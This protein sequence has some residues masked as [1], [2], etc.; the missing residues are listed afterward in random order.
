MTF[1]SASFFIFF[2]V[3]TT[4]YF[5]LP[6]RFR[7]A[8]LL[9]A[10]CIFYMAFVPAYILV[11]F[12]LILIDYT[13]AILIERS[14]G[15]RRTHFL[16]VSI[17]AMV[18]MLFVFKYFN[19]FNSNLYAL[20]HLLDW[21]YSF[22]FL[23]LALPLGLSFHTFQSLS[24]VIEVYKGRFKAERNLGMYAL[25]VMFYPQL[26]AGP[27]ERPQQL[28][29]Q[30]REVHYFDY[31]R[32]KLGLMRMVWGL[33]KKVAIADRLGV[34]VG[35]VYTNPSQYEGWPLIVATFFF[36]FQ[37]YCD[38]SAYV[39]IALG[40]AQVMGFTLVENFDRPYA[41][42]SIP[43]FW[44]R[45][46]I[47]L[48]SWFR[49]YFFTPLALKWRNVYLSTIV[50]FLVL[51][52]WHGANWTYVVMGGLH[53]TYISVGLF[54]KKWRGAFTRAIG[55]TR[56]PRLYYALQVAITFCLVSLSWI[57]FRAK[58]VHDALYIVGHLFFFRTSAQSLFSLGL[59]RAA[60]YIAVAFIL[61]VQLFEYMGRKRSMF[62]WLSEQPFL[63]RWS[64]YWAML[65]FIFAFAESSYST[66]IYFQF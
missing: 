20:A 56:V 14:V 65:Y 43:E 31:G 8:L 64:V 38:F 2:P 19:F 6:H 4:L 28:L 12:T 21:N 66:F 10:S 24:Y 55:L 15:S 52:L 46:H 27:I 5:L 29:P 63:L 39:D 37:L 40:A 49:D 41:S 32:V 58:N 48:S 9:V 54:T 26:V 62:L 47:S 1:D 3:V 36:A 17:I 13:T 34:L 35:T 60:F 25:Y 50:T 57:F 51:G 45:W 44:R 30:L 22:S 42:R 7:W 23:S 33:F 53:G 61:M 18:G 11:L 59:S 16:L